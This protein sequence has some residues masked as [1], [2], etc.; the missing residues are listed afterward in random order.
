M[1]QMLV[2]VPNEHRAVFETATVHLSKVGAVEFPS[3]VRYF[4]THQ[5]RSNVPPLPASAWWEIET[6][7]AA[8]AA[9][10]D[11]AGGSTACDTTANW[12]DIKN[13][14]NGCFIAGQ[15]DS[16][17]RH[18]Q[19][20]ETVSDVTRLHAPGTAPSRTDDNLQI[21]EVLPAS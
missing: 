11:V 9:A 15:Y 3:L 16:G 8:L 4:S 17:K 10:T 6:T 18:S 13:T 20:S 1:D 21:L 7:R 19:L 5:G 14:A 12:T 2:L